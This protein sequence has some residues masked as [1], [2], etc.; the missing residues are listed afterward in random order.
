LSQVEGSRAAS[1]TWPA[2]GAA[3]AVAR[4]RA[5]SAETATTRVRPRVV[6]IV[7]F[8]AGAKSGPRL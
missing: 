2:I 6:P 8:R 7:V 4:F 5:V 1:S 3:L